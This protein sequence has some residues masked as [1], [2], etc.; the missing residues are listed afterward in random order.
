MVARMP[1]IC[2]SDKR[3]TVPGHEKVDIICGRSHP[4]SRVETGGAKGESGCY[5]LHCKSDDAG[6]GGEVDRSFGAQ[7]TVVSG[8]IGDNG[9]KG[10]D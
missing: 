2:S 3:N 1:Y 8:G 7:R 10:A 6:A 5:S 9:Q 4:V